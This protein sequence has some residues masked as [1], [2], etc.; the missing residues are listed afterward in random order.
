MTMRSIKCWVVAAGWLATGIAVPQPSIDPE[1]EALDE[2][3]HASTQRITPTASVPA[4]A[5]E[6]PSRAASA[7]RPDNLF[8]AH[9]W[10]VPPPAPAPQPL[11]PVAEPTAPPLPFAFMGTMKQGNTVVYFLARGE[12]AYDAK[13]GDVIDDTYRI[14]GV[15][16]GQLVFTYLPLESRQGLQIG[17][18]E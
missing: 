12:R 17:E 11:E 2:Q 7:H 10:Y 3:P 9:S 4:A 13:V 8:A 14:D 1:I 5:L 16:N 15:S 18:Q 6:L